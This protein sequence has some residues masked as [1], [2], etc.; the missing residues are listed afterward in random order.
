[1]GYAAGLGTPKQTKDVKWKLP[2]RFESYEVKTK[3]ATWQ[4]ELRALKK[5]HE[6]LTDRPYHKEDIHVKKFVY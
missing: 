6:K 1:L 2:K 5:Q 3:S 4:R